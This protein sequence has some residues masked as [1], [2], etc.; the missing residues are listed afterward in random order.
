MSSVVK[1]EIKNKAHTSETVFI[2]SDRLS[3]AGICARA[4][5]LRGDWVP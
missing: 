4:G 3:I 2:I 5:T 1:L